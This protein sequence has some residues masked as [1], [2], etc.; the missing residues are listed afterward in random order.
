MNK[1]KFLK[2]TRLKIILFILILILVSFIPLIPVNQTVYCI[3]APCPP[4]L[5]AVSTY[6]IFYTDNSIS[7]TFNSYIIILAELIICYIFASLI[8]K[9][10]TY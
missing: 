8:S 5:T 10:I 4:T 3:K 7:Y 6:S 1:Y 9:K 2:P